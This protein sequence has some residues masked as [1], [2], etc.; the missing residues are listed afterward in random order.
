MKNVIILFDYYYQFRRPGLDNVSSRIFPTSWS[1]LGLGEMWERLSLGLVSV[2]KS[3]SRSR[4][5]LGPQGL[6]CK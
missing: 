4:Q 5:G 2:T 3:M 1:R 6:I